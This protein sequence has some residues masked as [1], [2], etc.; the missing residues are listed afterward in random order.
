[1]LACTCPFRNLTSKGLV[2]R[3]ESVNVLSCFKHISCGL[4]DPRLEPGQGE[5]LSLF[6]KVHSDAAP[7]PSSCSVDTAVLPWGKPVGACTWPL[8]SMEYRRWE[9]A[10][11]YLYFPICL[12]TSGTTLPFYPV[13]C[14]NKTR[15]VHKGVFRAAINTVARAKPKGTLRRSDRTWRA[16]HKTLKQV[17]G[18]CPVTLYVHL[19]M[20]DEENQNCGR[21][22][23]RKFS[24]V[25]ISRC[26]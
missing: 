1:M 24:R 4:D 12:M 8:T 6:Q 7:H 13:S 21:D 10:E 20:S 23:H 26:S 3:G 17:N 5:N 9:W 16:R 18:S 25:E 22:K 2:P 15:K 19:R 14:T 11:Q